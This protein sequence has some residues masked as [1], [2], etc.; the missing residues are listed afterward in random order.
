MTAFADSSSVAENNPT[1]PLIKVSTPIKGLIDQVLLV[2]LPL[3]GAVGAIFCI[4]LG[5]KYSKAEEPQEREKAKHHLKSAIIGF[6]LVFILV[7]ALKIAEPLLTD[8]M[9]KAGNVQ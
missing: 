1:V 5:V 9:K 3:V 4:S 2:L 6:S 8:W 7:V